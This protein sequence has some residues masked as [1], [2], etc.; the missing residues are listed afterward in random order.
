MTEGIKTKVP[1]HLNNQPRCTLQ[2]NDWWAPDSIAQP[3]VPLWIGSL[4]SL[5]LDFPIYNL[6]GME[7]RVAEAPPCLAIQPTLDHE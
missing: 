7:W 3:T 6:K 1:R 2:S 4:P 5:G